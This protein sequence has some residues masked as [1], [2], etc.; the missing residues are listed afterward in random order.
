MKRILVGFWL[1]LL[2]AG[3]SLGDVGG[4]IDEIIGRAALKNVEFSIQVVKASSGKKVYSHNSRLAMVPASNMKLVTT[5]AALKFLGSDYEF[6]TRVG[7]CGDRLV[8]VGSGDPLLG[9]AAT[10]QRYGKTAGWIFS[11]IVGLLRAR[12]VKTVKNIVID[13]SIFDDE[14]VNPN[15]PKEQLNRWYA[16]EVSGVNYN[17][18]C[19]AISARKSGGG[20]VLSIEPATSFIKMVNKVTV[21]ASGSSVIGSYRSGD[22]NQIEVFGKCSGDAGPIDVAIEHPAVFFGYLLAEHLVEAGIRPEG[23][24]MEK[25]VGDEC[26][27]KVLRE[28]RHTIGDCLL[29]C[30]KDSFGLAAECLSKSIAAKAAGGKNG[31][32]ER[33]RGLIGSFL[34]GL[35]IER[36]EFYID[37][38]SGLSRQNELSSNAIT[39]VLLSVYR[40]KDWEL[41]KGSL[42]VG[43]VDGTI[44]KYFGEKKYRGRVFGKTGYIRGVKSFSGVCSTADGDFIFSALGNGANGRT[45]EALNDIA[46]AI[47]DSK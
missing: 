17:G 32:W 23:E 34:T 2:L 10:D 19:V 40:S 5:A 4:R 7:L 20:V 18:N 43:G 3:C 45:R 37:D 12:G 29:R 39:R 36:S 11:D 47:I 31:G 42:A 22:V 6:R 35:G 9:D 13:S 25:A 46:K 44:R 30:N 14:R 33:G 24:L 8:V 1:W 27:F 41:Y 16:C 21:A 28:Y 15:W 26:Q 38:G